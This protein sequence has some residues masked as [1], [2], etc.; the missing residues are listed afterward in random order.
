MLGCIRRS[1]D[2]GHITL[3][4]GQAVQKRIDH[5]I[6]TGTGPQ[7]AR[8]MVA[9][10]LEAEKLEKKR[11][12]LLT[13]TRRQALEGDLLA[14]RGSDGKTDLAN[15][16]VWLHEHHGQAKIQDIETRRLTILGQAH[17]RLDAL[18]HDLR[19]GAV[20]GDLRRRFG[21]T[22]AR[23]DNVVR[24][25]FGQDSGDPAAKA[26]AQ[27]WADVS[28]DLRQRFNA[29]GGAIGQ[30]KNWGLPQHHDG[31]ALLKAGRATWMQHILPLLD[32]DKM[33][34]Q[35]TGARLT[36]E[37]LHE[38]LGTMWDRITSDGWIDREP[39]GQAAGKGALFKQ[40]A[41]HRFLHFK[42]ADAW[43][44][45]QRNFGEGDPFAAMMGHLSVMSRDIA[46]MEI[47]GPNPVAMRAYLREFILQKAAT[48]A[49]MLSR[50][51]EAKA[52]VD[53][54]AAKIKALPPAWAAAS[55]RLDQ[56]HAEMASI[57]AKYRP[58]LGGKPSRADRAKL[59][60]LNAEMVGLTRTLQDAQVAAVSGKTQV[61]ADLA[62]EFQSALDELG[63]LQGRAIPWDAANPNDA[64]RQAIHRADAMWDVMR[65]SFNA[66]VNSR[67]ANVLATTRNLIGAASLGSAQLSAF[68]DLAFG[69]IT[70]RF[71][72]LPVTDMLRDHVSMFR[73]GNR[74]EAV[75]AGLILDSAVHVMHQQARYVG[76]LQA[77]SV[78]SFLV[79]RVLGVQGLSAWTQAGKHAFGMAM[80]AEY[81]D[82]V[83]LPLAA[84][85]DALRNTLQRHGIDAA[86][87]DLIRTA[88][89]YE[90]EPGATFLRP[91]EIEQVAGR[92]AAE[93]YLAMIHRETTACRA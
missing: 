49:P 37:Q 58:Q 23:L 10:E 19:K 35:M 2:A 14:H 24:E 21:K 72:G 85:P 92:A 86:D 57:R 93:K 74:R 89:L 38:A 64:A 54:L 55:Q 66:P 8:E 88:Q 3:E 11:R 39:T 1:V 90:P 78:S 51:T 20:S 16:F 36:D 63:N 60:K 40:H 31:E 22:A 50:V 79:D 75:R 30:L 41:D 67:V 76:S 43:L 81:A 69:A 61:P 52:N 45:Y 25:A 18:L 73:A 77:R 65:G 71:V 32:R 53:T 87:W 5:I 26:L 84:L 62:A 70:R 34:S 27:A 82:R 15:A 42:D 59:D 7:A 48:V 83:S 46:T 13:E 17:A 12:A 44:S 9:K 29:A 28:E 80:Q 47:L 68:S 91:N 4:D 33:V 6:R 56:V